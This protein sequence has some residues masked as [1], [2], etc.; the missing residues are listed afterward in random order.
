LFQQY[1]ALD[2]TTKR[3]DTLKM[4]FD[5]QLFGNSP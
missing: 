4:S 1:C 3:R 2:T 5:C